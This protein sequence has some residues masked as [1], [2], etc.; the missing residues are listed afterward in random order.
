VFLLRKALVKSMKKLILVMVSCLILLS[1]VSAI[2]NAPCQIMADCDAGEWCEAARC[3]YYPCQ[4]SADCP[5]CGKCAGGVCY[6]D[7]SCVPGQTPSG[8]NP[9]IGEVIPLDPDMLMVPK[10]FAPP[11][12]QTSLQDMLPIVIIVLLI[13]IILLLLIKRR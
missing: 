5:E 7:G 8:G 13:V 9:I 10:D 2:E 12:S 1:I 6:R 3:K 4:T 11:E